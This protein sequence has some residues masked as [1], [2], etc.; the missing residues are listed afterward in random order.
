VGPGEGVKP[1]LFQALTRDAHPD[2]NSR[3]VVQ[4]SNFLPLRY[5]LE[6]PWLIP[7]AIEGHFRGNFSGT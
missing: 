1:Q 2:S 4:I 6:N 5:A 7:Q 3:S